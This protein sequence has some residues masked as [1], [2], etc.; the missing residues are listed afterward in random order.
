MR[1]VTD[2]LQGPCTQPDT[3]AGAGGGLG[4]ARG[5][6]E[7]CSYALGKGRVRAPGG[8][9]GK[10][11]KFEVMEDSSG[12]ELRSPLHA[13]VLHI[14][15]GLG[16]QGTET[17]PISPGRRPSLPQRLLIRGTGQE[18]CQYCTLVR[19]VPIVPWIAGKEQDTSSPR[20]RV[21]M[22][23]GFCPTVTV[24]SLGIWGIPL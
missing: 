11:I 24:C 1:S 4:V 8:T 5:G 21:V 10:A 15:L 22:S 17:T 20:R 18:T 12:S 3:R 2:G 13:V 16:E 7:Y 6:S 9:P 14:C 23:C 19:E